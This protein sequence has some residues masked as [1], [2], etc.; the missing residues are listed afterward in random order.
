MNLIIQAIEIGNSD[1][2]ELAKISG[3]SQ[4]ERINGQA[5]RL[6][7]ATR[8]EGVAEYCTEVGFDFAFV[9]QDAH[10]TDFG[11]VAMDMD[12]TLV[13]IESIDEMADLKGV[14]PQVAEITAST[15]LG[16]IDFAES[17]TRRTA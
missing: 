7:E 14:K 1:L 11:L 5:F 10:L 17:L 9:D 8:S 3:S 12:S 2:R 6:R 13:S 16:E 4:I 15:M